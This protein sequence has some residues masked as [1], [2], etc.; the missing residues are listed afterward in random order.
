MGLIQRLKWFHASCEQREISVAGLDQLLRRA[1]LAI[2]AG[3]LDLAEAFV[4]E[5]GE[6]IWQNAACMNVLGL[7]AEARGDWQTAAKLWRRA[8]GA[9]RAYQPP[10]RNLRRYFEMFQFGCS[11]DCV[12]FGDEPAVTSR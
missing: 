8:I 4:M 10:L 6:G 12:A 1:R 3:K 2:R 7:V 9:D 11:R 5:A